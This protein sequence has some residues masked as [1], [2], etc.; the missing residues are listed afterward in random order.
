MGWADL[1]EHK[2][3]VLG[4]PKTCWTKEVCEGLSL[5]GNVVRVEIEL[6]SRN[7]NAWVTFQ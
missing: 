5:Y 2:I 4:L 1:Q 7:Y 6:G 3:K